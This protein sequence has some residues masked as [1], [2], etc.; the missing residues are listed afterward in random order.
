MEQ[1]TNTISRTGETAAKVRFTNGL[2]AEI[3]APPKFGGKAGCLTPE[4]LFVAS[5]NACLMMS[6]FYVAG[7][8]KI[9]IASYVSEAEGT[10]EKGSPTGGMWF[11][12]VNV[13]A[14]IK[15]GN[16]ADADRCRALAESAEKYCIVSA[17]SKAPVHFEVEILE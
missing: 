16:P 14:R 7:I 12:G 8:K 17:T 13:L 4:E 15:P 2:E 5:V 3:D 1:F 6:Y 11:T 9:G 10:V